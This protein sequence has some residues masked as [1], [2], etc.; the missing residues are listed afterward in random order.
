[1]IQDNQIDDAI[2]ALRLLMEKINVLM[3]EFS[4]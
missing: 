1:M 3:F 2:K 4:S